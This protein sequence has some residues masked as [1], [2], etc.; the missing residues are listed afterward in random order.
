M[1]RVISENRNAVAAITMAAVAVIAVGSAAATARPAASSSQVVSFKGHLTKAAIPKGYP[2]PGK[3][4]A[5]VHK[6]RYP[7]GKTGHDYSSCTSI[8][9]SGRE[10]CATTLTAPGGRLEFAYE[11]VPNAT[12]VQ[13]AVVGGTGR[14]RGA[15]GWGLVRFVSDTK[16]AGT[17]HVR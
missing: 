5:I 11:V 6:D 7:N 14:Y 4:A 3:V 16:I 1:Q 15:S 8:S 12:V 2:R 17:L 10:Q 13:V 9:K